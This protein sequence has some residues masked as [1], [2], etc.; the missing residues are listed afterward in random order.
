[1]VERVLCFQV[2]SVQ[3]SI[4]WLAIERRHVDGILALPDHHRDPFDRLLIAQ[5]LAEG[6]TLVSGDAQMRRYPLPVLW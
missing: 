1:M 3:S 5:A 4:T 2:S 6:L